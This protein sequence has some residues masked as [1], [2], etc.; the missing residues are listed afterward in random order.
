MVENLQHK[1]ATKPQHRLGLWVLKHGG[2]FP[3]RL[4]RQQ[5]GV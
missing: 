3:H 4:E 2:C 1:S 5:E